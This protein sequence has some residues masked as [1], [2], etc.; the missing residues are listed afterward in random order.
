MAKPAPSRVAAALDYLERLKSQAAEFGG[1]VV[2][3]LADRARSVG[4]LAYEALATDPNM[5]RMTTAEFSEAS[6]RPT[7][8]LDQAAQDLGTIS[9]AIVTQPIQTGKAIVQGEIDRAQGATTSPR[10]AGKYAGSFI[11]PMRIA[12]ALRKTAPVLELDVYHGT[13]HRFPA[14]EA[15]PLGEFDASKIGTGEGAQAYG[16][17]VYLAED[18]KIAAEYSKRLWAN[19]NYLGHPEINAAEKKASDA[20]NAWFQS[21]IDGA[22]TETKAKLKAVYETADAELKTTKSQ[23]GRQMYKADLPDKMID[24]MLDWDEPIGAGRENLLAEIAKNPK[25][26]VKQY[27][28]LLG[29]TPKSVNQQETGEMLY[30]ALR[31]DLGSDKE[32]SAVFQQ[33]GFPGVKYLDALAKKRR[34]D[35]DWTDK[36]DKRNF[37]VFPGEEKKVKI[38][39]RK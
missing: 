20:S 17:G 13:P 4:G 24:K 3:N 5:G 27:E 33:A 32:A 11:D 12:A 10:A 2:E 1:G 19:K 30:K 9:K 28:E 6:S 8:R 26:D 31:E 38:L 25:L 22:P 16:H 7:P 21:V 14:T 15:N 37:V 23:Y 39:E 18:P 29:L 36:K 35:V 34:S